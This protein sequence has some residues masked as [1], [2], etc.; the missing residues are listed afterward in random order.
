MAE[1]FTYSNDPSMSY[2]EP[3]PASSKVLGA[4]LVS[5]TLGVAMQVAD[6]SAHITDVHAI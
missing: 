6:C 3:V 4:F 5:V 2:S 1:T